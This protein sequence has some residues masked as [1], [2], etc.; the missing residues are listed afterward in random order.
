MNSLKTILAAALI[1]LLFAGCN[2]DKADNSP[3]LIFKFKFDPNQERLGNLGNAQPMPS[4]HA[5]QS[6][7]FN[8][9]SAHYIEL[10]PGP[11]TPVG[12]GTVLYLAPETTAGGTKAIDFEKSTFAK[13]GETFFSIPIKDV[14]AGDYEFLRV[15][16]AYQNYDVRLYVDTTVTYGGFSL[17]VV[18]SSYSTVASFIGYNTYVKSYQAKNHTFSVNANKLQGYW[19]FEYEANYSGYPFNFYTQGQAPGTTVVNTM[20]N[21]PIPPGSCLVTGPFSGD[22]LHI[23]GNETKDVVVTVSL[24]TNKSFEWVE[25]VNDGKWEPSKGESIVD[26]GV[27]GMIPSAQ[28]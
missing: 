11:L 20:P 4:G 22:K 5:G 25:V 8:A 17:H 2:K 18:D 6:P 7:R 16:L 12:Q 10:A 26:M 9:M 21:S 1:A 27:R 13:D 23:T 28:Y 14:L 15:S 19:G 3:K 24:S